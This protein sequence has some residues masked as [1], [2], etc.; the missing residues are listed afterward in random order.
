MGEPPPRLG[1]R[2]C[3]DRARRR[4][5]RLGRPGPWRGGGPGHARPEGVGR[6]GAVPAPRGSRPDPRPDG[7]EEAGRGRRTPGRRPAHRARADDQADRRRASQAVDLPDRGHRRHLRGHPAGPAGRPR[8]CRRDRGDPVHRAV[9]A[10]LRAG[11]RHPRGVRRHVRHPGELPADARRPRR[12]RQGARA[13]HPADQLRLGALHAR[14][15]RA[16]RAR[17]ARHDAQRLDVRDPLPRHQPDPHL[18]RPAV[19]PSG[20]RPCRDH[21]QHRR[22]QLPHHRRRRR[23]GAHR[24]RLP[25]PQR[26][27]RQ[28]GRP[29]GLAAWSGPRVR[30]QPG[31]ARQLPDGAGPRPAGQGAVPEG[32]VEVDAADSAHDRRRVPRLP[33]RRLLQPRRRADRPGHPAGRDDDRGRGHAVDLRPRPGA[34][35]RPLRDGGGRQPARGLRA[36]PGRVHRPACSPGAGRGDR[37]AR[38]DLQDTSAGDRRCCPRSPTAPSA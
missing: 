34:A 28:G 31:P 24:D 15:R 30:D 9:P 8:G 2:R 17:T 14:D 27:L 36:G 11:G 18:R 38:P 5:A 32:A 26:V 7:G 4:R 10:G 37:P 33:A 12:V 25:A 16:G 1:P 13:L 3:R 19:Q 23:G 6:V 21:H 20:A 35:E 29:R 22:G